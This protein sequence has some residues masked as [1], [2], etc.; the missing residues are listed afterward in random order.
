MQAPLP[1]V[2]LLFVIDDTA[3]MQQEQEA[4][5]SEL[6]S[7]AADLD[8]RGVAWQVGVVTTSMSAEAGG[9][10]VGSPYVVTPHT[11]DRD[12]VLADLLRVGTGGTSPEAGFAAAVE[13]LSLSVASGPNAGFR[14][15]DA[16]LH[17]I[18]VSDADDQSDGWL[19]GDPG[20][21]FLDA[22]AAEAAQTGLP[23]LA[24]AIVG[25]LPS[26]CSS[27]AG[28]AQPGFRYADVVAA[29][30]GAALSI[31]AAD[32]GRLLDNLGDASIALPTRF[33]L[34]EQPTLGSVAVTV[35][36]VAAE[37][38]E[39]LATEA[40]LAFDEAPPAGSRIG[41]SYVVRNDG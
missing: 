12:T 14:R 27:V 17:T 23:A 6:A 13:A 1:R 41:V 33:A 4:L 16:V 37:G 18:F 24:S 7:L 15:P 26:G 20:G 36:G 25:P 31:C 3:S 5:S 22:L 2:D 21:V 11:D 9:W 30:G 38:W 19:G 29:A 10:L 32:F 39:L 40:V 35:D 34:R 8:A 28:T